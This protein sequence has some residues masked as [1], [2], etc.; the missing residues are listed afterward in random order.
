MHT[1]V[2]NIQANTRNNAS[3]ENFPISYFS[4]TKNNNNNDNNINDNSINS[5]K[6]FNTFNHN[7]L[8]NAFR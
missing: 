6:T 2:S 1:N 5:I 7:N 4:G 8:R 3:I